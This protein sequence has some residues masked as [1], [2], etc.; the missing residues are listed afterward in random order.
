M[1]ELWEPGLVLFAPGDEMASPLGG[2]PIVVTTSIIQGL[3]AGQIGLFGGLGL[4]GLSAG[5]ALVARRRPARILATLLFSILL[6]LGLSNLA[7]LSL[8][9]LAFGGSPVALLPMATL[10]GLGLVLWPL[11]SLWRVRR[12]LRFASPPGSSPLP[13]APAAVNRDGKPG[14]KWPSVCLGAAAR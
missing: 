8:A 13:P 5:L 14:R 1:A 10:V 12:A 7:A 11:W 6:A 2:P 4:L 3:A 9:A